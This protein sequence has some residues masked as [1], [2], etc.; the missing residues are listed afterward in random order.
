MGW[1]VFAG[2]LG[3]GAAGEQ[4]TA[5]AWLA[6]ESVEP[7]AN[8]NAVWQGLDHDEAGNAVRGRVSLIETRNSLVHSQGEGVTAVVGLEDVVVP[9]EQTDRMA[10]ALQRNGIAVEVHRFANE[11][12]GFRK[13]P[14]AEDAMGLVQLQ[15]KRD[16]RVGN[17]SGGQKQRLALACAL[18]LSEE[19]VHHA[20][21]G[22]ACL[23]ST[24]PA[25]ASMD[26]KNP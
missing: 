5:A 23:R 14:S 22:C 24:K 2:S 26:L 19:A 13:G 25:A 17:L 6:I 10:E 21:A 1:R 12:H 16:S 15:E 4:H 7:F 3:I 9:P 18:S 8:A 20:A 11:G